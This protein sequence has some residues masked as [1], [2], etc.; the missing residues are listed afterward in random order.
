MCDLYEQEI[1]KPSDSFGDCIFIDE[2]FK[3]PEDQ[4]DQPEPMF[5][6]QAEA[7]PNEADDTVYLSF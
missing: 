2:E 3:S 5:L 6:E 4:A 7:M 1:K